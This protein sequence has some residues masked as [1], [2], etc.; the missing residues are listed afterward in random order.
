[1]KDL[2][3]ILSNHPKPQ[4]N[5]TSFRQSL[6]RELLNSSRYQQ[7]AGPNFRFAFFLSTALATMLAVVVVMLVLEPSYSTKLHYAILNDNAPIAPDSYAEAPQ[8]MIDNN[9]SADL[10][11]QYINNV[12][13]DSDVDQELVRYLA[14]QMDS[15]PVNVRPVSNK[16]LYAVQ[17]YRLGNGKDV[18]VYTE[19]PNKP[20]IKHVSY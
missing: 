4:V 1:M 9:P 16:E 5:V 6:R 3:N 18:M 2:E 10:Q 7:A 15:H 13:S 8:S 17:K 19:V 14:R 11:S 12:L 20:L